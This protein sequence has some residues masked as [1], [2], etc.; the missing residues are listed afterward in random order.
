MRHLRFVLVILAV[1]FVLPVITAAQS[2]ASLTGVV[3][4]VS[5]AVVPGASIK[6][7]NTRTGA[8]LFAKTAG[9]G[10]A[11]GSSTFRPGRATP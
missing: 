1:L 4:D 9:D 10:I 11:T 8:S 3:M 5:G 6:L 7:T 2:V